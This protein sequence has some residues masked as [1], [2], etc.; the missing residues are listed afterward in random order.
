MIFFSQR[1]FGP[2]PRNSEEVTLPVWRAIVAAVQRRVRDGSFGNAFPESCPEYGYPVG[3]D[4]AMF[5]N[6]LAGAVPAVGWPLNE[7]QVP[8]LFGAFDLV[9]FCY[10]NVARPQQVA[11]HD[12]FRHHRLTFDV[13]EG[14][15][16]FRA[17]INGL[18][19]RHGLA[20]ELREDGELVRL[21][22][23]ELQAALDAAV[24]STGDDELNRLLVAVRTKFRNP[25]IEVRR[26]ALERLWDAWE[27]L[28][29]LEDPADKRRSVGILLDRS[30]TNPRFRELIEVEAN[31]LTKVGNDFMIRHT[32]VGKIPL[33]SSD[34]VDFLFQ[35]LF[36]LIHL[37]LRSTGRVA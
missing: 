37:T 16:E 10:V 28:K 33:D 24:F 21:A 8:T 31:N 25:D 3:T 22:A 17:E 30:A 2:P 20:F 7:N 13:E 27:R 1:E 12:Y 14:R 36:A 35:I 6:T 32:E 5:G 19:E 9:Q 15:R 4:A 26:E 34:Q 11:W 23:P 29:T 18:F